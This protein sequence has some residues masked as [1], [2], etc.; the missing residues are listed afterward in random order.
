MPKIRVEGLPHPVEI[1]GKEPTP[2]EQAA[3][4]EYLQ[5][6]Q[7]RTGR[8]VPD[9]TALPARPPPP[10][11]TSFWEDV[12]WRDVG[13][14]AGAMAGGEVGFLVG[15]PVGA[16][17]G[18]GLGGAMG[19][20][21]GDVAEGVPP[22]RTPLQTAGNALKEGAIE[23]GLSGA[24]SVIGKGIAAIPSA[25]GGLLGQR[26]GKQAL[27]GAPHESAER[28]LRGQTQNIP[29]SRADV[30]TSRVIR[31]FPM[32]LGRMPLMGRPF[33]EAGEYKA[34]KLGEREAR[35]LDELAPAVGELEV[36]AKLL[37][38]GKEQFRWTQ[39]YFQD[40]YNA[41]REIARGTEATVNTQE[42][43]LVARHFVDEIERKAIREGKKK[44]KLRIPKALKDLHKELKR[45]SNL[46]EDLT[47][48]QLDGALTDLFDLNSAARAKGFSGL[49]DA[50]VSVLNKAGE[51]AIRNISHPGLGARIKEMDSIWGLW[52]DVVK[53]PMAQRFGRVDR[54]LLKPGFSE[55]GTQYSDDLFD[56]TI[57]AIEDSPQAVKDLRW[58]VGPE[59][60][61]QTLRVHLKKAFD[62]ARAAG[63]NASGDNVL[64]MKTLRSKTCC[65]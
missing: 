34:A 7:A 33:R 62:A 16:A 59:L 23:F 41:L 63:L 44:K 1:A 30:S 36:G 46:P 49:S 15:G 13:P 35:I 43:R 64:H 48:D 40:N 24:G 14:G 42:V 27:E 8:E 51:D 38:S 47:W 58:I 61:Q 25:V 45:V 57:K 11:K 12:D 56:I 3:I 52:Q 60:T 32:V 54:K 5:Q 31:G 19:Y 26:Y 18:A 55:P 37:K 2:A 9:A 28:A 65:T 50:T 39:K 22:D 17:A 21:A 53:S 4:F 29:L 20:L 10:P 6:Y